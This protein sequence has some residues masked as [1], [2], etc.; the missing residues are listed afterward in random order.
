MS[1][2]PI[3]S[4][5][6]N[7]LV[8]DDT[9]ANLQ[10]LIS[11]LSKKGYTVRPMP[12]GKLALQGIHLD[13]PDL[14]L[15]DI[16]MPDMDGYEVCKHLKADPRTQN[17]PVI[18]ISALDDIFDKIKAFQV[19]G[20]DY[21][22][23]PF[24][25][26]EVLSRVK[27]HI[28]LY[29]LQKQLQEKTVNQ[30]REIQDKNLILEEM[31][32]HLESTN[33]ELKKRMEELQKAQLQ[34][35]QSEKMSTLGQLVAGVAH[36]INNPVGFIEGNIR[37]ALEYVEDLIHLVSLYENKLS[38]PDAEI[39][40]YIEDIN[41]DFLIEDCPKAI[42]SMKTGV[43]R[44]RNISNALRIFSRGDKDRKIS[45]NI[46]DGIDSTLLI[47]KHRLK[48]NGEHPAIEV[49]K[50]YGE[51]PEIN[52]F[53]GKLNQVFMNLIA[54]AIDVLEE[55]NFGKTFEEIEA[56]PNQ[57]TITTEIDSENQLIII[58]IK[59]N[60]M[61]MS[62]EVKQKIF[63]YLFTTK[64]VGKGTGLGL[65]ISRQIVEEKHGGKLICN[66]ALGEGAEF[67]IALPKH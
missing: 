51:L 22:T 28:T 48:D 24:H 3:N 2:W 54:N 49:I 13:Y 14:I 34:L 25:A 67:V 33:Q 5:H 62:E 63:D 45:F 27:T 50:E 53:P 52:C 39:Q 17:I 12:S 60:G 29:R 9:P 44:I 41:L 43:E 46:H 65:S 37:H 18:F 32:E 19:G 15:L 11:L 6:G 57:I 59:D 35:V 16:Q 58:R 23:K 20:I 10:I 47:L 21:I 4:E 1:Y 64:G 61:G 8:I 30:E 42:A 26:L 38:T 40:E 55:S 56:R 31:I 66:S 7:I 36:E